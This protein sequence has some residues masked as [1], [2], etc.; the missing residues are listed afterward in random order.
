[1]ASEYQQYTFSQPNPSYVAKCQ[2]FFFTNLLFFGQFIVLLK[3]S[4]FFYIT[5]SYVSTIVSLMIFQNHTHFHTFCSNKI[6]GTYKIMLVHLCVTN[7]RYSLPY[8]NS[9][10][11]ILPIVSSCFK[12]YFFHLVSKMCIFSEY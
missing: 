1:M 4:I 3:I 2:I 5:S 6:C 7:I 9:I 10:N 11:D 8:D 12:L